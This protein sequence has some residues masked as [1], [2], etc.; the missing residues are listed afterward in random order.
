[1]VVG[2]V[3][4]GIGKAAF[5]QQILHV[6]SNAVPTAIPK[7]CNTYKTVGTKRFKCSQK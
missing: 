7:D 6:V 2:A 5:Q 4:G 1:M 3:F